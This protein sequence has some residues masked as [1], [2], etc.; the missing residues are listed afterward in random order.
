MAPSPSGHQKQIL[1]DAMSITMKIFDTARGRGLLHKEAFDKARGA[2][3][4][5]KQLIDRGTI[6]PDDI[7]LGSTE[8][9][10]E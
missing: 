10:E 2:V 1:R 3:Y 4:V 6:K 9:T 5:C 7:K 8:G